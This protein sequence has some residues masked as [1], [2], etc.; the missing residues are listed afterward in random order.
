M[1]EVLLGFQFHTYREARAHHP[2]ATSGWAFYTCSHSY[3]M[4]PPS[5]QITLSSLAS[6][7]FMGAQQKGMNYRASEWIKGTQERRS[8]D[9]L[10]GTHFLKWHFYCISL[11]AWLHWGFKESGSRQILD[12]LKKPLQ[13]YGSF[14]CGSAPTD[15]FH[16]CGLH[17]N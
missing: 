14:Q 15:I 11:C 6:I 3:L 17:P 12:C 16:Q 1:A 2:P 13:N 9:Q 5:F 7:W 10:H 4:A 8:C